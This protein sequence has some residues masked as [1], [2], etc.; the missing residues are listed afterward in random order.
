[1]G[2]ILIQLTREQVREKFAVPPDLAREVAMNNGV[3]SDAAKETERLDGWG[4]LVAF[5]CPECGGPMWERREPT[6]RRYRC[7]IGHAF[8]AKALIAEQREKSERGLWEAVRVLEEEA[9]MLAMLAEDEQRSGKLWMVFAERAAETREKVQ[10]LRS[11]LE[12][13]ELSARNG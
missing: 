2:S 3:S 1:M 10:V 7:R 13:P 11:L 5:G 6:P 9:R 8:T 4:R 12:D